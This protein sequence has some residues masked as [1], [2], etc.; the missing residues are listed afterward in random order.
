[1]PVGRG[2]GAL[3]T[4]ATPPVIIDLTGDELLRP[5]TPIVID[6]TED[7]VEEGEII[8]HDLNEVLDEWFQRAE[9]EGRCAPPSSPVTTAVPADIVVRDSAGAV[10]TPG[11]T[12]TVVVINGEATVVTDEYYSR[13]V[14]DTSGEVNP[15]KGVTTAT[16]RGPSPQIQPEAVVEKK[17]KRKYT[18]S[19]ATV[20]AAAARAAKAGVGSVTSQ[21]TVATAV[22]TPLP[23][24]NGS[25]KVGSK[26]ANFRIVPLTGE[27][28]PSRFGFPSQQAEGSIV[29]D[30][31]FYPPGDTC[32]LLEVYKLPFISGVSIRQYLNKPYERRVNLRAN[33][34]RGLFYQSKSIIE[35]YD[36]I[37]E[38]A[39]KGAPAVQNYLNY[40]DN[41]VKH[42]GVLVNL[43]RGQPKIHIGT[44]SYVEEMDKALPAGRATT[45]PIHCG[46]TVTVNTI[47]DILE[48]VGPMLESDKNFYRGVTT[49]DET[50]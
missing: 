2:N 22:V 49:C 34:F 19:V 28:W 46:Y 21:S 50:D 36:R 11:L 27:K 12:D 39:K 3:P 23:P 14:G 45:S 48:R 33:D 15:P 16:K 24:R 41:P 32:T 6:L 38:E 9:A 7:E 25:K 30:Q 42:T 10:I 40:L 37:K 1:M 13:V 4:A 44:S 26:L 20:A 8:G 35:N 29:P 17:K 47:K 5:T 43:Y 31:L 18:K